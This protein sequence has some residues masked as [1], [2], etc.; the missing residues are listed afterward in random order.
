[1]I[2]FATIEA[3]A[4]ERKGGRRALAKLLPTPLSDDELRETADADILA[5]MALQIFRAGFV[6]KVVEHK[7]RFIEEA[8][9]GFDP[10]VIAGFG[11]AEIDELLGDPRM[12]RNRAKVEA[13]RANAAWIVRTSS[14][15]GGFGRYLAAWPVEDVVGLWD[16]LA[17]RGTRLGGMTGPFFL[18]VLGKDTFLLSPD[19]VKVLRREK[20]IRGEP[21]SQRNRR[22]AQEAFNVWRAECGRPLCQISRIV[23]LSVP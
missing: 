14:A 23:S 1:M 16:D 5:A 18:R 8:F 13:V 3:A 20:V 22:A 17:D 21:L 2:R 12:I 10:E 19:V 7:W 4:A 15:T 11:A 9:G 6:W